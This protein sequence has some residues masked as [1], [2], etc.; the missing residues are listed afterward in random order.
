MDIT[1]TEIEEVL[2]MLAETPERITAVAQTLSPT[3]LQIKP[4]AEAWSVN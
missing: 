4:D 2:H 3:Q 1:Q